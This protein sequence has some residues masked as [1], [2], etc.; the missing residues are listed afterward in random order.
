MKRLIAIL[1]ILLFLVVACKS[2]APPVEEKPT[3][4]VGAVSGEVS[5]VD[6]LDQELDTSELDELDKELSVIDW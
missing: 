6:T 1:F 5:D 2:K 3:G 4:E